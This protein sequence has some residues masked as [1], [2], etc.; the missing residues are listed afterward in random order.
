VAAKSPGGWQFPAK[1]DDLNERHSHDPA[2]ARGDDPGIQ[3]VSPA[4][5]YPHDLGVSTVTSR[6]GPVAMA[7][8]ELT[9]AFAAGGAAGELFSYDAVFEDMA[10][11]AQF[12]GQAAIARYLRRAL[13]GLPYARA[14]ERHVAGAG[15]GGGYEW[16]AEGQ[17]VAVGAGALELSQDG[18]ITKFIVVWDGSVLDDRAIT[19]L[20]I[21]A[22][23]N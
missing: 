3:H 1:H 20:A 16:R 12:R 14:S 10:P 8:R 7:A 21:A 11:R 13:P 6:Q 15:Q 4:D 22:V 19:A 2:A 17:P 23:D 9:A 18:K 5:S